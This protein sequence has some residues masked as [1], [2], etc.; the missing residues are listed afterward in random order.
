MLAPAASTSERSPLATSSR[1]PDANSTSSAPSTPPIRALSLASF[2]VR[3]LS[4][5]GLR[6]GGHLGAGRVAL[7][8]LHGRVEVLRVGQ[9]AFERKRARRHVL[10]RR[11]D[12]EQRGLDL[13]AGL[14]E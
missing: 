8:P 13:L 6:C 4:S 5:D 2:T 14:T 10:Q 9:S 1:K 12:F 7:Q 11:A 3:Y